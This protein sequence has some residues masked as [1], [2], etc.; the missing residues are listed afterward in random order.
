LLTAAYPRTVR[1]ADG[2]THL[3][4]PPTF[5]EAAVLLTAMQ[6][7]DEADRAQYAAT[8]DVWLPAPVREA[9]RLCPDGVRRL[10]FAGVEDM[11]IQRAAG[12]HP[13]APP[14]RPG[15]A[16]LQSLLARYSVTYGADPWVVWQAVPFGVVMAMVDEAMA[17]EAQAVLNASLAATLP[18]M[19]PQ[20]A[21]RVMR[22]LQRQAKGV[23]PRTVTLPPP[24]QPPP[25]TDADREAAERLEAEL[26]SLYG[27]RPKT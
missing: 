10:I 5:G 11:T 21:R 6:S 27:T 7:D 3:V 13:D 19:K 26:A 14:D 23:K 12:A 16:R 22:D 4:R 25:F 9:V 8:L 18:H 2:S 20:E 15:G 17:V 24:G 1:L